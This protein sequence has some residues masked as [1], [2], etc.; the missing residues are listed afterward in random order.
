MVAFSNAASVPEYPLLVI[1]SQA[2]AADG[3]YQSVLSVLGTDG[4]VRAEMVDRIIDGGGC[5][6]SVF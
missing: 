6:V 3:S 5:P 4:D 1:G 2:T